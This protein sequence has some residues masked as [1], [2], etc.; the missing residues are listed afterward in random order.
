MRISNPNNIQ[1]HSWKHVMD[2]VTNRVRTHRGSS[3]R[4]VYQQNMWSNQW[5]CMH[6]WLI[7]RWIETWG[8][9]GNNHYHWGQRWI[10]YFASFFDGNTSMGTHQGLFGLHPAMRSHYF[11]S[12]LETTYMTLVSLCR[13]V[14]SWE[15]RRQ[16]FLIAKCNQFV[17]VIDG[18]TFPKHTLWSDPKWLFKLYTVGFLN[19][20][21][22]VHFVKSKSC[23]TK[24]SQFCTVTKTPAG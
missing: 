22:Q 4:R 2:D 3:Y 5:K 17:K 12:I 14:F 7:G 11:L 6:Y 10:T 8:T 1:H 18:K 15:S 23:K 16:W 9:E 19:R 21:I 13:Y 24:I 20:E